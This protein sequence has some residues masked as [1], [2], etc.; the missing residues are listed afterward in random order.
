MAEIQG[1]IIAQKILDNLKGRVEK[2]RRK[3][4]LAVILVGDDPVSA[5]YIARKEKAAAYIGV[6]FNLHKFPAN[7]STDQ[8]V[9]EIIRTQLRCDAIMVQ[10]PLPKNIDTQEVL[11]AIDPDK[12]PDCLSSHS[13]GKVGRGTTTIVSPTASSVLHI[14]KEHDIVLDGQHFV[15]VGQGE[16]VGK[17]LANVLLNYPITLTV[18]GLGTKKLSDFTKKADILVTGVGQANL[19]NAAMVKKDVVVIDCGIS[20]AQGKIV[21]DVDFAAVAKKAKLITPVPGGVGPITVA[22]LFENVIIL[23]EK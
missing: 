5:S 2:L 22:K 9:Q 8:L 15:V 1:K 7:I 11:D 4:A 16:L 20:F 23:A 21:G 13:L 6:D 17:P 14:L 10:L 12:D 3:P 18:C 19:I